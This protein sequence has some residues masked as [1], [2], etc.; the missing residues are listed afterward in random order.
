MYVLLQIMVVVK[1]CVGSDTIISPFSI[2][3]QKHMKYS[4]KR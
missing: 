4:E 2:A 1:G 3:E